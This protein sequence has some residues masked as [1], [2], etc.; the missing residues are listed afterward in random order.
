MIYFIDRNFGTKVPSALAML[1]L[2]V[3]AHDTHFG[4]KTPD[5]IWLEE[6]GKRGWIVIAHDKRFR[7]NSSEQRAIVNNNV[8]CFQLGAAN[9][10]KWEKVRLLARV[11]DEIEHLAATEPPPYIFRAAGDATWARLFPP[12]LG[13]P[14]LPRRTR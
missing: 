9:G 6:V 12:L 4:P 8:G 3:E 2:P 1:G 7:F 10:T 11:W 13:M 5:E 14:P